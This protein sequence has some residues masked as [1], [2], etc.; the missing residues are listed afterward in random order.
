[1]TGLSLPSA[2]LTEL[3]ENVCELESLERLFLRDNQLTTLPKSIRRLKKLHNLDVFNNKINSLKDKISAISQLNTDIEEN[4]KN[5]DE[6]HKEVPSKLF[7][8]CS[9]DNLNKI[10]KF[11]LEKDIIDYFTNESFFQRLIRVILPWIYRKK[12][13]YIFKK[14]YN[15]L[16]SKF[17]SYLDNNIELDDSEINKGLKWILSFKKII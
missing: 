8:L 3:P 11:E 15:F 12:R 7:F 2:N 13:I 9:N 1:M 14:Y 4:L 5:R 6:L 10:N 16:S 17:R